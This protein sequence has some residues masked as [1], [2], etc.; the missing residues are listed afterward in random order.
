MLRWRG[1]MDPKRFKEYRKDGWPLC[2]KC[3]EDELVSALCILA[4]SVPDRKP[5]IAE[6]LSN[7]FHCGW[8]DFNED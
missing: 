1:G 8:C 2:P 4:T 5:T 6:C 3:G 7:G